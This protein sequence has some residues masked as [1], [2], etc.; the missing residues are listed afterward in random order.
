[1]MSLQTDTPRTTINV[2][3]Q[4]LLNFMDSFGQSSWRQIDVFATTEIQLFMAS[5]MA[6]GRDDNGIYERMY[7][8]DLMMPLSVNEM[9]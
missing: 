1:M 7:C 8:I 6:Y 5:V 2:H 4:L 3:V 9:I